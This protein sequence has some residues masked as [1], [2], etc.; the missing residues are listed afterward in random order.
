LYGKS[1]LLDIYEVY[2]NEMRFNMFYSRKV[3]S[4]ILK[5]SLEK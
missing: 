4:I 2:R 3:I 1:N 5:D